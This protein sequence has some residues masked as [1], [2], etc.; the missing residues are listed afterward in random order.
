MGTSSSG[1]RRSSAGF[2]YS[3]GNPLYSAHTGTTEG[4]HYRVVYGTVR[5]GFSPPVVSE[6]CDNT[7]PS[8]G[9]STAALPI[10]TSAL[11]PFI[12]VYFVLCR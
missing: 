10:I 12:S 2:R 7:A 9:W 4:Y 3:D 5:S 1:S 6:R 11:V 8:L